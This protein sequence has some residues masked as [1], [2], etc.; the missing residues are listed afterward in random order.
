ME[1]PAFKATRSAI[2][3]IGFITGFLLF[4][5][6]FWISIQGQK[7][8]ELALLS[9]SWIGFV[10]CLFYLALALRKF[11]NNEVNEASL[12]VKRANSLMLLAFLLLFIFISLILF[13]L[14][15]LFGF[16]FLILS[17]ILLGLFFRFLKK[18]FKYS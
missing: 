16:S 10:F 15:A 5:I 9:L 3:S 6:I 11:G 17:L 12:I 8:I 18:Y 7:I 4:G 14:N 13:Y 2:I 1:T